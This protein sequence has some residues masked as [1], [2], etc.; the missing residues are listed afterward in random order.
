MISSVTQKLL[1]LS[2]LK[3][4]GPATLRKVYLQPDFLTKEI[5][6]LSSEV[7]ALKKSTAE[8]ALWKHALD[9]AA[10][11]IESAEKL[12]IRVLSSADEEYPKLLS[13]SKNN[14]FILYVR[15]SLAKEPNNSV[16]IIGTREPTRH[17]GIITERITQFFCEYGWSVVSGLALG[18]DAIAHKTAV[19]AKGHTVAVLAHGL[20]TVMP[21]A[22]LR[23]ADEILDTGGALVSEYPIGREA[24]PQQFAQR[25]KT[26]AGLAQGVVM[27]Q[28]DL[29][30]GSLIASRAALE[31]TRWL[32]VP[33]PTTY[34]L[35]T[36]DPKIQA[37]IVLTKGSTDEKL[38]LLKLKDDADTSGIIILSGKEDYSKC[39]SMSIL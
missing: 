32:A 2:M 3:G 33:T 18:C 1:A 8:P 5:D 10:Q 7:A 30:G 9:L 23:L 38:K 27:I 34:D 26:Q 29:T 6:Q 19:A 21:K 35:T 25:D 11:Q 15:G 28:S 12:N 13:D 31:C 17:G 37:N 4:V 14:P 36:N 16:A 39:V 20:Q 24:I 22:H